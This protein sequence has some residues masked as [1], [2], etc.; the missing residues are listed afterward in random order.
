MALANLT[1]AF[2]QRVDITGCRSWQYL[3]YID[4]LATDDATGIAS[5]LLTAVETAMLYTIDLRNPPA[6]TADSHT[7]VLGFIDKAYWATPLQILEVI[8]SMAGADATQTMLEM[9]TEVTAAMP[10]AVVLQARQ[11]E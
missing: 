9:Q 3:N 10:N 11:P 1:D 2:F 8:R 5:A 7:A 6:V 4:S